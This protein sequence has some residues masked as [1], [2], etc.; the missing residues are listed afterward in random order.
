MARGRELTIDELEDQSTSLKILR[1]GEKQNGKGLFEDKQK[2]EYYL[3]VNSK[4]GLEKIDHKKVHQIIQENSKHTEFFKSEEEKLEAVKEKVAKYKER[5]EL[6]KK[7]PLLWNKLQANVNRK[8]KNIK[9][10]RD[11]TRTW[12]HVDMDAFYAAVEMRDDPSLCDK[13]LA[14]GDKN[15]IMT[16]NYIA[17]NYGIRSGVPGFIGKKLCPNLI[18]M[19]PDYTKY[20]KASDEIQAI[21]K[22]YDPDLEIVGLDEANMD[23]TNYLQKNDMDNEMGRLFIGQKI[24]QEIREKTKMTASCGIACNKMLAKVCSDM[25]KPDGQTYLQSSEQA[26]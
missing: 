21:L 22:E 13:P 12:I 2:S 7:D 23:V 11:L 4:A 14:I 24:R 16:T 1:P 15:M 3:S 26:I 19:R 6:T 5:V 10:E 18:F 17:R 25:N 9:K 8:I 20:R